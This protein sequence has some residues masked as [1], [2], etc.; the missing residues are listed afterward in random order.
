M[1]GMSVSPLSSRPLFFFGLNSGTA[2]LRVALTGVLSSLIKL[3][4]EIR[5]HST[6]ISCRREGN[7][8]WQPAG[9]IID[10][11]E[12]TEKDLR[13]PDLKFA[14]ASDGNHGMTSKVPAYEGKGRMFVEC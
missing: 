2:N 11:N 4:S 8:Q 12:W 9:S 13:P 1:N 10:L 3:W 14:T 5:C 6:L 7:G